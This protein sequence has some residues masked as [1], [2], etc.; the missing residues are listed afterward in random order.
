MAIFFV[1]LLLV[2]LITISIYF[3]YKIVWG[4]Y[5]LTQGAFY[6]G[7]SDDR[8]KDIV[9]I[10]GDIKD[11]K[12]IDLGSGDGRILIALANQGAIATGIEIDK[13]LVKKSCTN[14]TQA[15]LDKKITVQHG[16]MWQVDLSPFD[17][18]IVYGIPHI[19]KRLQTKLERELKL[20]TRVVSVFFP[21]PNKT[22]VKEKGDIK[23]YSFD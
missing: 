4:L 6:A 17:I 11:K 5:I 19:M 18:V 21:F 16:N 1:L 22:V 8:V 20:G 13:Q 15:N 14:I 7:T 10:L 12:V 3:F 9:N 23:E 2:L